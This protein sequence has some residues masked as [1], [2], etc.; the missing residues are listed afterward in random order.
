MRNKAMTSS[1]SV[2]RADSHAPKRQILRFLRMTTGLIAR[3]R[4]GQHLLA[5]LQTGNDFNGLAV[6]A[7]GEHMP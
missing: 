3:L 5:F 6:R 4:L 1:T 7:A 2:A